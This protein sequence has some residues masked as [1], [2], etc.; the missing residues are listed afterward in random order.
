MTTACSLPGTWP[1]DPGIRLPIPG[2]PAANACRKA[3]TGGEEAPTVVRAGVSHNVNIVI[4]LLQPITV[5]YSNTGNTYRPTIH[6]R[7][8]KPI[9][10]QIQHI[11]PQ[12]HC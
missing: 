8:G 6:D 9:R 3:L 2:T 1:T 7:Q 5:N 10:G 12:K 11:G 4:T